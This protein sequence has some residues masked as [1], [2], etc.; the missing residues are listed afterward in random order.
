M[1]PAALN[2]VCQV[3]V[4]TYMVPPALAEVWQVL[5]STYMIPPALAEVWQLMFKRVFQYFKHSADDDTQ[6]PVAQ[7]QR[8]GNK[9]RYVATLTYDGRHTAT[10]RTCVTVCALVR[11]QYVP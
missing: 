1:S 7:H 6:P 8:L 11:Q 9:R 4:G 3:L 10:S 5:D 2:E